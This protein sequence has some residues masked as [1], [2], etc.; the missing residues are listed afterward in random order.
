MGKAVLRGRLECKV[1]PLLAT[2]AK[3]SFCRV[4]VAE[5]RIPS[6]THSFS[7]KAFR[8]YFKGPVIDRPHV[9]A[10]GVSFWRSEQAYR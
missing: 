8:D 7:G 2:A 4:E 1:F 10:R 9:E 5:F 3:Q 6:A